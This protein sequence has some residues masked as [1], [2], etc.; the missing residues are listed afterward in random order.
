MTAHKT[1]LTL[2]LSKGVSVTSGFDKLSLSAD[3]AATISMNFAGI[4]A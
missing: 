2:N 1:A 4:A 3:F